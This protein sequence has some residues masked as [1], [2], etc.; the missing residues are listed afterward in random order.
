MREQKMSLIYSRICVK[1]ASTIYLPRFLIRKSNQPSSYLFVYTC[2]KNDGMSHSIVHLIVLSDVKSEVKYDYKQA[3]TSGEI[4]SHI[5]AGLA[6][7]HVTKL[8]RE[9]V[10]QF[11][12]QLQL[13]CYCSN[14]C[15]NF[16]DIS[17]MRA[18]QMSSNQ[19]RLVFHSTN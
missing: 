2:Y 15:H 18:M 13:Y 1:E 9:I 10:M 17:I 5:S 12:M 11:A 7:S 19:L 4:V 6:T 8:M 3:S 16:V 14:E